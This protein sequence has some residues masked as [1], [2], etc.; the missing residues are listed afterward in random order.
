MARG[1][2]AGTALAAGLPPGLEPAAG[3]P[4]GMEPAAVQ[5]ALRQ[6][7]VA[8][9]QRL[10]RGKADTTLFWPSDLHRRPATCASLMKSISFTLNA[11][12]PPDSLTLVRPIGGTRTT[13]RTTIT[14]SGKIW[15]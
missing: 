4:P 8:T 3:L 7:Q 11:D 1:P 14:G 2:V 10:R 5:T 13:M 12:S 15:P 9:E 6:R